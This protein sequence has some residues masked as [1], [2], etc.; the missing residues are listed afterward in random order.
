M[1]NIL[2]LLPLDKCDTERAEALVELGYPSVAPIIPELL[3]WMQDL[4][5]PV[6]QVLAP[7]LS[8]IGLPLLPELRKIMATDDYTW[9][10]WVL[11]VTVAYSRD[12][13]VAMRPDLHRLATA[14]TPLEC[15]DWL[16][17]RA[18]EILATLDA[19]QRLL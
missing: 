14:A 12:L 13:A 6:A 15:Q 11:G 5:W 1:D 17:I 4:N 18:R 19:D 8:K 7:M 2:A 9:Q 3:V 16:D 10:Y